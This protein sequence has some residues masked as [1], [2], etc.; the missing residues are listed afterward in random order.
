MKTYDLSL[1][2]FIPTKIGVSVFG[3]GSPEL[4]ITAGIHG[5]EATGVFTAEKLIEHLR[6]KVV[7]KGRV[8]VI[9][10]S[11]PMAF[12]RLGRTSPFDEKDLNRIF[13][14]D[15]KGTPSERL[16]A[17]IWDESK[18]AD[19]YISS[20]RDGRH[21]NGSFHYDG[22]AEDIIDRARIVTKTEILLALENRFGKNHKFQ[23]IEYDWGFHLEH[24]PIQ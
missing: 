4:L 23:I 17:A 5:E 21:M 11:N 8:K 7:N 19:L 18:S 13:P 12:R 16:A 10:L 14:G 22:G 1:D 15:E 6:N 9:R 20:R 24:D 3:E 2:G